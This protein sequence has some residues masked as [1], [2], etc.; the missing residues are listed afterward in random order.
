MTEPLAF[1]NMNALK[2]RLRLAMEGPPKVSQVAVARAAKVTPTSVNDWLSGKSRTMAGENLLAVAALLGVTP[3]W[4]A[5]GR[6]QM[7]VNNSA[8]ATAP[9]PSGIGGTSSQSATLTEDILHEALTLLAHDEGHGGT[10]GPRT[11]TRR[12]YELISRVIADGGRLTDQHNAEFEN[13]V[14]ARVKREGVADGNEV[15]RRRI[16]KR[17]G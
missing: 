16:R 12:L 8:Q 14:R 9:E 10:Y 13:E 17:A 7:R 11:R 5:T 15:A 1:P 2:D 3:T 4:L 6:G